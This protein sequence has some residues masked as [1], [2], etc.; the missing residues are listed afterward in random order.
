[1][2]GKLTRILSYREVI[3]LS[4]GA[5]IGW[6][7]VVMSGTWIMN[8]GSLGAVSAFLVG[9]CVV[10][11]VGLTYAELASAMPVAGGEHTYSHRALGSTASFV[12]TWSIL[13][14]YV[15]VV[16][17][18]AV[19]LPTVVEYILPNLNH[20]YLWTIL[21][22]DVHTSWVM[23]GV[24]GAF[25]VS[26]INIMGIKTAAKIQLLV[27]GMILIGGFILV[28]GASKTGQIGNMKPFFQNQS[29]GFLSVLMMVPFMFVG[30]DVIPQAAEELKISFNRIGHT[31]ILSILMAI[32]WYILIILAISLSLDRQFIFS[33]K[34]PAAD[35][36]TFLFDSRLM[37]NL[38]VIA[39][40]GGLLTSWNA[41]L[42][43]GSRAIYAMAVAGQ[44]PSFLSHLHPKYN[45]P[46]KAIILIGSISMIAPFFGRPALL[47]LVNAG[48]LGIV[49]AYVIVAFSFLVLR[50]REPEMIR[51]YRV[52]YGRLV[53]F[54]AFF[55]SLALAGLYF[56]GSPAALI[57]PYE[58]MLV[59]I[60]IVIGVVFSCFTK[61]D[62]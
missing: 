28:M 55:L 58:W 59:F 26:L 51:P 53:G 48:G 46:Y 25:L 41:F 12:C 50:Y 11:L 31:I 39:G 22:W 37:G 19:A 16:S 9:G 3:A 44:L 2:Q 49:T 20:G 60:W 47:W 38:L 36:A 6:S 24:I 4:F 7:W 17:F 45:T 23:V 34:L 10:L 27:T 56:P 30:F 35:A 13:F 54:S 42:I 40:I 33:S 8:A 52:R 18:E 21:D 32:T 14:G 15:S 43:G 57:W 61:K 5:M 62:I 29:Q 1:M